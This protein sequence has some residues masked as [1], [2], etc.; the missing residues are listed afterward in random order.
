MGIYPHLLRTGAGVHWYLLEDLERLE[1]YRCIVFT[2]TVTNFTEK[3]EEFLEKRLK[4]D[5]R[6]LVFLYSSGVYRD[7]H[8]EFG[9]AGCAAGFEVGVQKG[10]RKRALRRTLVSDPILMGMPDYYTF[11]FAEPTEFFIYPK[12]SQGTSVLFTLDGGDFPGMVRKE[13]GEWT[14]IYCSSPGLSARVLRGIAAS[15]GIRIFNT[16][17]GD[18]TYVARGIATVHTHS[19]GHRRFAVP[20]DTTLVTEAISGKRFSVKEGCFEADLPKAST[21][22]FT[23]QCNASLTCIDSQ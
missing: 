1:P 3:Q 4:K 19:G 23:W 21:M 8:L 18:V 14:S 15:A 13:H 5:G 17:P 6:T 16:F 12:P 22:I 2:P 20:A 10:E 11:A 9:N 7:G